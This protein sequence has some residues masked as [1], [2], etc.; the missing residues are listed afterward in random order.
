MEIQRCPAGHFYDAERYDRCP[1]CFP[2]PEITPEP[3]APV[4]LPEPVT[5]PCGW[6]VRLEEPERGREYRIAAGYNFL[7]SSPEADICILGDPAISPNRAAVLGYDE[8]LSLFS[9]GPCGGHLPVRVNGSM[10]LDAVILNA[11]DVLTV[12]DTRLLF[13]PLCG[14]QFNW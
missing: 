4:I 10:I 12:G 8:K 6:L 5:L 13:L 14:K 9:F 2:E 11:Y 7:G 3:E 1:L